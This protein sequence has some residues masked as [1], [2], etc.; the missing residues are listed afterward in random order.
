[1]G[2]V[3]D[4]FGAVAYC[5]FISIMIGTAS[6]A[7]VWPTGREKVEL[8]AKPFAL[9][10]V[11][12]LDSPFREAMLRTR[13]YLHELES[14]RLL[15]HFRKT[16]GLNAPGRPLGGWEDTELRGHT[17]GHYLSACAMMYAADGDEV[18]KAKAEQ[19]V[20]ELATCQQAIGTGYLSAFPEEQIERAIAGKRV[21]APWYTLHKICAGLLDMYAYVGSQ[22]ALEVAE[23]MAA[24][25]HNRLAQLDDNAMQEMLGKTEQGGMNEALANLYGLTGNSEWLKLSF[26]FNQDTYLDPLI[27]HQDKLTGEHANSMIPNIVGTARQFELTGDERDRQIAEFFWRCVVFGRSYCTGGTSID[28]RWRSEPYCL[29]E[30]LGNKTQENCCT[31]NMLKLTRHLFAWQPRAELMDYYEQNLINSVLSTQDPKTGMMTYFVPLGS[32]RWK[33]FNTPR[34]SFWCCTGTG[35]ESHSKYGESIYFHHQDIL[36]V[37]L[38]IASEVFWREKGIVIRQE[39]TFPE[40]GRT[41]II[42]QTPQSKIFDLR[43]RI[44]YWAEG[45]SLSLNGKPQ[46]ISAQPASYVSIRKEWE[47]G[48]RVEL[49]LPMKLWLWRMPDDPNLAA[50]LYGPMVLAGQI[51]PL[52]VSQDMIYT[53]K[54]WFEFPQ[55]EIADCPV[56]V[57]DNQSPEAWIQPVKGQLLTFRTVNAGRPSDVTLVPYYRLWDYKY[58]VYWRLT[59]E[60]GWKKLEPQILAQRQARREQAARQAAHLALLQARTVDVVQIG[61]SDSET[62]HGL[63]SFESRCGENHGRSWRDAGPGGWFE[64]RLRVLPDLPMKLACTY[65]GGDSGRTFAILVDAQVIAVQ[66]LDRSKPGEFIE[67][68]YDIPEELTR[69]KSSVVVRFEGHNDSIVG[70][71]YGCAVLKPAEGIK[72]SEPSTPQAVEKEGLI[73]TDLLCEYLSNP[74][75]IDTAVPRLSW[76]LQSEQRGQKQTSYQILVA[77]DPILLSKD[78]GNLWDSGKVF[79]DRTLHISYG[80]S[81]LHSYQ[82]CWWKVRVWDRQG[83]VSPWSEPAFWSMGILDESEWKGRWIGYAKQNEWGS[84]D[85]T[86]RLP[87]PLLRKTFTLDKDVKKAFVYIGCAG[88]YEL[89]LNGQKVGDHILDP[90]FT[91]YDKRV[92]YVTYDVTDHLKK[93]KNSL[94]IILG[95]GWMNVH[96]EAPWNFNRAPWRGRPRA[97][98]QMRIE[99]TDDSEEFIVSDATWRAAFGPIVSDQIREGEIYDARREI[100]GWNELDFDDADWDFAD[101]MKAPGGK[102]SAQMLPPIKIV[103]TIN[104]VDLREVKPGTFVYDLG[105][106]FAGVAEINLTGPAGTQVELLYGERLSPDGT[107]KQNKHSKVLEN[108][109]EQDT[110]ILKGAGQECWHPRFVYHGFRYV[111]VSG[112]PGQPSLDNLRGLVLH[113]AFEPTGTFECSN[114]LL[115][116]LQKATCWSY[117][118]NFQGYPTDCPHREKNG[119]TGDAHLAAEQAMYNF[120]NPAGYTKWILDISDEQRPTGELPGIVPT[121]GWG[122]DWG[123]GPAWDSAFLLIP[124]YLYLYY[125]DTAILEKHYDQFKLYV[126]YLTGKSEGHLVRFGLGD[127]APAETATPEIITSTA[128]YYVDTVILSKMA[129]LLGKYEDA[130][131]Y[132][133][134]AEAIQSAFNRNFYKGNGIYEPPTQTALSCAL[135]QGLADEA[136]K[137]LVAQRLAEA[138]RRKGNH[139]DTGILG[140][141]YILNALAENGHFDVA[142]QMA[143]QETPPGYGSWIRR[144]AT[145]LWEGWG[146]PSSLNHIMFGDISAWFYKVLAGIN[147][148]S[149]SETTVGFKHIIIRPQIVRDLT[150]V[151]AKYESARG[152]IYSGYKIEDDSIILSV[153]IPANTT[154][155]VYLPTVNAQ[156]VTESGSP[157]EKV[158]EVTGLQEEKNKIVFHLQSGSYSF[159]S[160]IRETKKDIFSSAERG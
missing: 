107:V 141:K 74:L 54:N 84:D 3:L 143:I 115:N 126:N 30:M 95:N 19:I 149:R 20:E 122:Y 44:P 61:D 151:H 113:T 36:W 85:L 131:R 28:E 154:A 144:G 129:A 145:T 108:R 58:A 9:Q 79:S 109:Y 12:L 1:M 75:G 136:E 153:K 156:S 140:A 125:G 18:L 6:A 40:S 148:D 51:E 93:T 157:I 101:G 134:L 118:S 158:P 32:G 46:P 66:K 57:T 56:M 150:Y 39:T 102:L 8:S 97:I 59:D 105:Q 21:W 22:K 94:G 138:V 42:V 87:G 29:A 73:V 86:Q 71:I 11:R 121:S 92:L 78:Q 160:K 14:D 15:W 70:G 127:W 133:M 23:K 124:W 48:D 116:T 80:G 53:R 65:W 68:E 99:Y 98:L 132:Q 146:T 38:F 72:E 96:T 110:Y 120:F 69:N 152:P 37:N 77:S 43:V 76:K 106:N 63:Q 47:N 64:Y 123:N 147:V 83:K 100:P 117:R 25:M 35:M 103:E 55:D 62:A 26:R 137:G 17:M 119:W 104:P 4:C 41:T 67:V 60:D 159:C 7:D 49:I 10:D 142:Y 52:R 27:K 45:A 31:Y 139:I 155:T 5:V 89:F 13:R 91:R 82:R 130:N 111:Q 112:F 24:W 135:F 90:A 81:P 16:A 34:D 2:G 33:Y 88:Y 50:V 128:Y 114:D